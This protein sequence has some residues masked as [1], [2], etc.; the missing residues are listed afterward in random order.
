M[1]NKLKNV[2]DEKSLKVFSIGHAKDIK[3]F[4]LSKTRDVE[5]AEDIV[6]DAFVKIWEDCEKVFS[7]PLKAICTLLPIIFFKYCK[8]Q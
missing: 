8:T 6:Q 3:R 1:D 2:C 5:V 7:I 4:I